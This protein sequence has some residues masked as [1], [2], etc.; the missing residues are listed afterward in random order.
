MFATPPPIK[1]GWR[2]GARHRRRPKST[3]APLPIK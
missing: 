1:R 2:A 3:G